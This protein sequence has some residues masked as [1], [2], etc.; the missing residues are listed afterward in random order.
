M[1]PEPSAGTTVSLWVEAFD[2]VQAHPRDPRAPE[3]LYRLIRVA[4]WGGNHDHLGRRAFHLV[5]TR[6]PSSRWTKL[7]PFFYD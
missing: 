7:S 6:Y 1:K 3:T 4:R 2:Y 5:H